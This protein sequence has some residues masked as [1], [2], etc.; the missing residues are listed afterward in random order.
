MNERTGKTKENTR[1]NPS[2]SRP[3]QKAIKPEARRRD[4]TIEPA[5]LNQTRSSG[6][7][8]GVFDAVGFLN[9]LDAS[10]GIAQGEEFIGVLAEP[11][12][13]FVE[14]LTQAGNGLEIHVCLRCEFRE[15][16]WGLLIWIIDGCRGR[17]RKEER[18]T[19]QTGQM[20]GAISIQR[21]LSGQ[22]TGIALPFLAEEAELLAFE[23]VEQDLVEGLVEVLSDAGGH[24][25]EDIIIH[26][27]CAARFFLV[28]VFIDDSTHGVFRRQSHYLAVF[29]DVFPVIDQQGFQVVR[30]DQLDC[31]FC[32]E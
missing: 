22:I 6:A 26:R 30:K 27:R 9:V 28:D 18:H 29:G 21:T 5:Q 14:F 15:S 19:E 3:T 4:K 10:S 13:E 17:R 7:R 32:L 20:L 16:C 31:R 11:E 12:E 8:I 23:L 25:V 24:F 1:R 2:S